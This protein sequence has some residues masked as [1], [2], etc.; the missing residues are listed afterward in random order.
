MNI[1]VIMFVFQQLIIMLKLSGQ[2]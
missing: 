1:P 2:P